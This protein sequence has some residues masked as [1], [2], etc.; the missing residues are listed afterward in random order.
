M[1]N[2]LVAAGLAVAATVAVSRAEP[3]RALLVREGRLPSAG[4]M[5]LTA[6]ETYAEI[7]DDREF[8]RSNDVDVWTT[9]LKARYGL[10][11]ELAVRAELPFLAMR[12]DVADAD[13]SGLGDAVVGVELMA[14]Q[15]IFDYPY[16]MPYAEAVLATGDE[17]K[18]LGEGAGAVVFGTVLGTT[19]NDVYHYAVDLRYTVYQDDENVA[20]AGLSF[21]WDVS[22]Q[23]AFVGEGVFA[24]KRADE[25]TNTKV[26]LAGF[27]YKPSRA[28]PWL[29]GFHGGKDMDGMR[30]VIAGARLSYTFE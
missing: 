13:E 14:F 16:F 6:T 22:K 12:Y 3:V 19:A 4:A 30:D 15:D 2:R 23:L 7:R 21:S 26:L 20:S 17:D 10:T 9:T 1:F 18:G 5:E 24:E 8:F 29:L 11:P 27:T 28:S 25:A